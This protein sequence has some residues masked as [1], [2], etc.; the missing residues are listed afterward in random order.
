M[1]KLQARGSVICP[2][3]RPSIASHFC[4][5]RSVIRVRL[6]ALMAAGCPKTGVSASP[7]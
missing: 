4:S 3:V 6:A 1:S 7:A 5:T 2:S